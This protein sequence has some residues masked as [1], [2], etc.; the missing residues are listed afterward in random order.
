[1]I[2]SCPKTLITCIIINL[3]TCTISLIISSIITCIISLINYLISL[4]IA[5]IFYFSEEITY[6]MMCTDVN[7]DGKVDYM[8]FTERFHNPARDI[9]L[10][11]SISSPIFILE[12]S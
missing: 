7:N 2:V 1:M 11:Y 10:L 6:L 3:I 4:E 12:N 9:G 8:E 5:Q